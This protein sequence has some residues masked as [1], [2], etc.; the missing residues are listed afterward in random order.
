MRIEVITRQMSFLCSPP[1]LLIKLII[2][3]ILPKKTLYFRFETNAK[4]EFV[5]S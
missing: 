2:L 5:E 4:Q 3:V 1:C